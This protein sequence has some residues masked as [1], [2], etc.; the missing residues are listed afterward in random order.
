MT[1]GHLNMLRALKLTLASLLAALPTWTQTE[2]GARRTSGCR[3]ID[4]TVRYAVRH[5]HTEP[6]RE[7]ATLLK[8]WG[9]DGKAVVTIFS[10]VWEKPR[11]Y[12]T[13]EVFTTAD[14]GK[15]WKAEYGEIASPLVYASAQLMEAPSDPQV[16]YRLLPEVGLFLRSDDAGKTWLLPKHQVETVSHEEFAV[17]IGGSRHYTTVFWPLGI[18]PTKPLTIFASLRVDPW[19]VSKYELPRHEIKSVFVSTNGGESWRPFTEALDTTPGW[20]AQW[21]PPIGIS[22]VNPSIMFGQGPT[23][24]VKSIDGGETW[25][26]VGQQQKLHARPLYMAETAENLKANNLP[27]DHKVPGFPISME[28]K[29]FLLHPNDPDVVYVVSNKG[30]HRSMDGGNS[31]MLLDLG[32]D[33]IDAVNNALLNPLRPNELIV[34]T[35]YGVFLSED[36]GC[37]FRRIPHPRSAAHLP[38]RGSM[39][40]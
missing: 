5:P 21:P 29:Q 12:F 26:A 6:G 14:M 19:A 18:H 32:I 22:L 10:T 37:S 38:T 30:I 7:N 25:A 3:D 11:W 35:G 23:G 8:V 16:I 40:D 28:V 27:P 39:L 24:I 17:R 13:P 2:E 15:T 36:R 31:W 34:G 9:L 1:A 4:A 33:E 20:H